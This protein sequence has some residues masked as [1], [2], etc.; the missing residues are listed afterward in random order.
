MLKFMRAHATSWIIKILLGLIIVVFIFW[1]VGRIESKKKTVVATVGDHFITI[2]EFDR[3][4]NNLLEYYRKIFGEQFSPELLKKMNI[5]QQVLDQLINATLFLQGA[6]RVGLQVSKEELREAILQYPAF[7]RGGRFDRNLY[8]QALRRSGLEPGDFEG[9]ILRELMISRMEEFVG[10]TTVVLPPQEVKELYFLENE[11]VNLDFIKVS[12]QTFKRRVKVTQG[13]LEGYY[14]EHREEFRSAAQVKVLYLKFS[15][16]AHLMEAEV[17]PQEIQEYY[18]LNIEQYRRPKRVRVRHILIKVGPEAGPD[19]VAKARKRAEKVLSEARRG[20]DFALLARK[21]SGDPSASEGGDLGYFSQGEMDPIVEKAVFH[22]GK[23]EISSLV[24]SRHGFHIVK[25]EDVQEG[26]VRALEEV[27]GEIIPH[28]RQEKAKD[29]A[30]IHAEDAAY[31]TKKKGGLKS[32]AEGEGLQVR[33]AGPFK[34][35]EPLKGLGIRKR[36]SSI[37]F[38]LGKGEISSAFQ[39]GEDYFVLQVV[40]T[41]P[42]QIPPLEEVK[43]RVKEDLVSSLAKEMAQNTAQ[44]LLTAWRKGEGFKKLLRANGLMVE[45]TGYFKRSSSSAPHI[46]PLGRDA[47]KLATLTPEDPWSEEVAEVA[48]AYFVIKLRG[49]KEVSETKYEKEK[50]ANQKRFYSLKKGELLQR[51]LMVMRK[52]AKIEINQELLGLYK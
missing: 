38:T 43:E 23:G 8:L 46:G 26:K 42:P 13:E 44:R 7:Q 20:V 36:F 21:Y 10:D 30:A 34:P 22:L 17:S 35:G 24:R 39:D 40:D 32:Y 29:L 4:Y 49:V 1:G 2:G 45:Q 9:M 18:E 12:P 33:E 6:Q 47:G 15:P 37:A 48:D 28:L 11:K 27:K 19:E 5:K 31:K 16:S 51:W 14:A 25:V 50:D 41:I 52:E 3:A